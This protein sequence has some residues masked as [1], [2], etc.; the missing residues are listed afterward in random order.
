MNNKGNQFRVSNKI[1]IN[2]NIAIEGVT[3]I[4]KG[5]I[6]HSGGGSGGH[7]VYGAYDKNGDPDYIIDDLNSADASNVFNQN[8]WV[9]TMCLYERVI[10]SLPNP[11]GG[12][13]RQR[14]SRRNRNK[15]KKSK[16]T[17]RSQKN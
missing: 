5:C 11:G 17:R 7:Y 3:F 6:F 9:S 8:G 15:S 12:G 16:K 14:K 2:K 4:R 1:D 13:K 10:S